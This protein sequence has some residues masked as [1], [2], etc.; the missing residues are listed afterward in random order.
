[1]CA[2]MCFCHDGICAFQTVQT[3][4]ALSGLN[5]FALIFY[6][7]GTFGFLASTVLT[8]IMLLCLGEVSTDSGCEE[9]LRRTGK[10]TRAPYLLFMTG[11]AFAVPAA[12]RY[13]VS[14]K[15][16][17]GLILLGIVIGL[18]SFVVIGFSYVYVAHLA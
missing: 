14:S 15:T 4:S 11:C 13:A 5:D 2:Y 1:M 7:L 3:R 16:L 10:G 8:V 9:F 17:P 12:V 18:M 6:V